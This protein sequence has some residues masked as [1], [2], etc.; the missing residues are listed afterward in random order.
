MHRK[1]N[2]NYDAEIKEKTRQTNMNNYGVSCTFQCMHVKE[3][4]HQWI[5]EHGGET[6]VF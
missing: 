5:I 2:L 6:N 1:A 4:L 3:K